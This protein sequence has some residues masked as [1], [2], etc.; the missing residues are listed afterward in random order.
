MSGHPLEN[1]LRSIVG[2]IGLLSGPALL[3]RLGLAGTADRDPPR[4]LVRPAG[5]DEVSQVLAA[6]HQA[7]VPV[8]THGG[9]TGLT[10]ATDSL[11]GDVILSTERMRQIVEISRTQRV[12]VV[13]AGVPL[14]AVQDAA[15]EA[16]LFFPLD[17]GARGTATIGGCVAT[18]AGGNRVLRFGMMRDSILGLEVVLAD[19]TVLSSTNRLVKNNAGYDL[20]QLFVGSEGT[21]GVITKAVLRLRERPTSHNMA[22]VSLEGFD[23][24]IRLLAHMDRRLGGT[25]SAF[26]VFGAAFYGLV[27][28]P[29]AVSRPPLPQGSPCYV[30]IES[31]GADQTHDRALFEAALGDAIEQ[32]LLQDCVIAESDQQCAALWHM[33]DDVHQFYR[34]GHVFTY[35][36]SLPLESVESYIDRVGR[37]IADAFPGTGFWTYGH[38]GDDNLHVVVTGAG[39]QDHEAVDAIIYEPLAACQG[40]IS[41][42]HGIGLTKQKWLGVSRSP[43]EIAVMKALR[44]TLDPRRIL[45]PRILTE[46]A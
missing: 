36:V 22:L 17:L 24:V 40:S 42:E 28:T 45:N 35:D 38:L 41:G 43:A 46:G 6:C 13:E 39:P 19:G 23:P 12:A 8:I 15:T 44:Q 31:L 2:E 4:L 5:T 3:D 34:L 37:R 7:G 26:E 10:Q 20:K 18:N 29:P 30:L 21:L 11:A 32:G 9:L 1:R 33:R 14:A 27:T 16:D 25:L